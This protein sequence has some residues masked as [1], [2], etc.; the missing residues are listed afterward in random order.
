MMTIIA[1]VR[2]MAGRMAAGVG[3]AKKSYKSHTSAGS[4]RAKRTAGAMLAT[5]DITEIPAGATAATEPTAVTADTT[6]DIT[7][8][9]RSSV[10]TWRVTTVGTVKAMTET[11]EIT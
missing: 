5:A 10:P 7:A 2:S 4:D 9:A 3:S 1:M 11:C 6:A 8:A